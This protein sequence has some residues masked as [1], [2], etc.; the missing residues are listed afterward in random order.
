MFD[1]FVSLSWSRSQARIDGVQLVVMNPPWGQQRRS[2]DRPFLEA[3]TR[4]TRN[5]HTSKTDTVSTCNTCCLWNEDTPDI[6]SK[7]WKR[8][9]V[10]QETIKESRG[11]ANWSFGMFAGFH[12]NV[13]TS[14]APDAQQAPHWPSLDIVDHFGYF[15]IILRL[16]KAEPCVKHKL[17]K[18]WITVLFQAALKSALT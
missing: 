17:H 18:F 3:W 12:C 5:V 9:S 15:W 7:R 14:S 6:C 16:R 1:V 13:A 8:I 10:W 2:A 11:V 4:N